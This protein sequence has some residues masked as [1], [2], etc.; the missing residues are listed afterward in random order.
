LNRFVLDAGPL[1][2]GIVGLRHRGPSAL[3]VIGLAAG[4]FEAVVCPALLGEVGRALRKPYFRERITA[5]RVSAALGAL[6]TLSVLVDDPADPPQVLRDPKD[7]YLLALAR[8]AGANA[9]V[10]S[11]KDLLEHPGLD[12]QAITAREACERLGLISGE[13]E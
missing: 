9:I 10:S 13:S 4:R 6:E 8:E 12:P 11:D 3:L 1:A 5:E 2:S 7:D